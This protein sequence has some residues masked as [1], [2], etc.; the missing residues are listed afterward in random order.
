M[1]HQEW[2]DHLSKHIEEGIQ[3]G[4][5]SPTAALAIDQAATVFAHEPA[6]QIGK[7]PKSGSGA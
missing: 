4:Y 6:L 1:N 3:L 7:Q 2:L 5:L